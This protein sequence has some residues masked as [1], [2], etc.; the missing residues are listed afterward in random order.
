[1]KFLKWLLIIVLILAALVLII[2]LFLPANVEISA[3]REIAV[4]PVQ[5]FL[6]IATYTDRDKWDPWLA[7]DPEVKWTGEAEPGYIGSLYN[8]NGEKIGTGQERVDS[9]VF[10]EYIAANIRFGKDQVGSLVEWDLEP[11]DAGTSVTWSFKEKAKYPIERLMLKIY[12]G[13]LRSSFEKGLESLKTYLE[14]NP[15]VI[16]TLG[17][18]ERAKIAPMLALVINSKGTM[19]EM[20]NQMPIIFDKLYKEMDAQGLQIT[21]APFCYYRSFNQSSGISEYLTGIHVSGKG[22]DAGDIKAVSYGSMDVIQAVHSGPYSDLMTSYN[23]IMDYIAVNQIII[24]GGNFE[25]Y[26]TDPSMEP[27]I[28]KLQTIIAF[29]LR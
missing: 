1:M 11:S 13:S 2:P 16:S 8:W 20:S 12:K 21:G 19:E 17:K 9:V 3:N 24:S 10:G 15:P 28:T 18:I 27:D 29:P 25:F 7:M 14:S 5:A 22:K 6:N 4:S 26:L 23:K